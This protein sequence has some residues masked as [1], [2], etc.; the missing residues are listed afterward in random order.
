MS[1][2]SAATSTYITPES[3]RL[4][5]AAHAR[6]LLVVETLDHAAGSTSM[7]TYG[8]EG[9]L[10]GAAQFT[11]CVREAPAV[12]QF[13]FCVQHVPAPAGAAAE[14]DVAAEAWT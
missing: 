8:W 13:T 7:F 5:E 10:P 2:A 12:A 11:F 9:A 6:P 14:G 4:A 1:Q 3:T